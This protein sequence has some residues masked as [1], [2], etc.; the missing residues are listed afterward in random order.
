MRLLA[1]N[2]NIPDVGIINNPVSNPNVQT[3]GGF[4]SAIIPYAYVIAGILVFIYLLIGGF[5]FITSGG[6]K[7]AIT[8][9]REQ[10]Y[11]AL[12]GFAIIFASYFLLQLA[13]VIFG[14]KVT[15]LITSVHAQAPVNIGQ[16]F[17]LGS[18]PIGNIFASLTDTSKLTTL[19]V[20]LLFAG[21]GV[22]FIFVVIIGGLRYIFSG[23]DSQNT[24]AARSQIFFALIGL[25]IVIT[26]YVI[27][28]LLQ[29]ITGVPI[30]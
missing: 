23:G 22:T 26:A 18:N 12:I 17:K 21:A 6:D 16:N 2:L 25:L 27:V 29:E 8:E 13:E 30:V 24:A 3:V 19:I 9:A 28:K 4:I 7:Q 5:R 1:Q 15:S 10:I 14:F 11:A 20:R